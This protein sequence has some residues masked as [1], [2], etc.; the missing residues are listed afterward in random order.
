[1]NSRGHRKAF[2]LQSLQETAP[3]LG[4]PV[5]LIDVLTT[6]ARWHALSE[7]TLDWGSRVFTFDTTGLARLLSRL[8]TL[9]TPVREALL[10]RIALLAWI[11]WKTRKVFWSIMWA[12]VV[13][14]RSRPKRIPMPRE[15]RM[16]RV[17][18]APESYSDF[19]SPKLQVP[20]NL[21]SA[22]SSLSA[23]AI[24]QMLHLSQ[25]VYPIIASHQPLVSW[26]PQDRLKASWNW[27]YRL[28]R[29]SPAWHPDLTQAARDGNLLGALATGGPF[30]KLLECADPIEGTY[31]INLEHMQ[32]YDVRP[33]LKTIGCRIDYRAVNQRLR[34]NGISYRGMYAAPGGERWADFERIALCSLLT[35][36][37]VW[38]HGMQHHVGGVAPI[39]AVS[40]NL[41]P[42]HP[43]RRLLAPFISDT[44]STNY[45]TH[46]TLRRSGFDVT[47][48]TFTR[49]SIYEYYDD[50]AEAF[51]MYR[52]D[53]RL[54]IAE[55][56]IPPALFYPYR[57]QA[58]RY[59]ELFESY[60]GTYIGLYYPSEED[61]AEDAQAR[62][63]YES[64][65]AVVRHGIRNLAPKLDRANLIKLCAV[66]MYSVSVEH[67]ENTLWD[68]GLF[69]PATLR[70]DGGM[71][72]AGEVQSSL[73]FQLVISSATNRLMKDFSYLA[74]DSAA[75][76]LMRDF[77]ARLRALDQDM[78]SRADQY[79]NVYPRQLEASV[80]A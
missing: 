79:W 52:M 69:L 50:G 7:R 29:L 36:T 30:A 71:Q 22:E 76:A 19:V 3:W 20:A 57:E 42:R 23:R 17:I 10:S 25:D 38:R 34:V 4:W 70:E 26:E 16:I 68:Y 53:P 27:I 15:E 58:H 48:F 44:L 65:D 51:R 39:A 49:Q 74:L 6:P 5:V 43:L 61:L 64:V 67:E 14:N 80:S 28:V 21:P 55:R 77:Q 33:G 31:H 62:I 8:F 11:D 66:Y 75:A 73:N 72:S 54:S 40:H 32:K 41:P 35:H 1:M 56:R 9:F 46:L 12:L 60:V 37:T 45:H 59:M 47:G 18:S 63:W 2:S 13:L 24:V 78:E